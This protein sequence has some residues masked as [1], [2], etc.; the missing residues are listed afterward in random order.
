MDKVL[1]TLRENLHGE[2]FLVDQPRRTLEEFFLDVISQARSESVETAG[3]AGGGGIAEYLTG[4]VD[5]SDKNAVL[6]SLLSETAAVEKADPDLEEEKNSSTNAADDKIASVLGE[7][8]VPAAADNGLKDAVTE[9]DNAEKMRRAND[10]L[11]SLLGDRS[12]E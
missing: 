5:K 8:T 12:G 1:A 9:A 7:K 11:D 4:A 6:T 10:K 2:E 3:V